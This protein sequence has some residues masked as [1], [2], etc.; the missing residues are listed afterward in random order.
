MRTT[1][2][3]ERPLVVTL[4][5]ILQMFGG[6]VLLLSATV[7]AIGAMVSRSS[8]G[9]PDS[10][11]G[12]ASAIVVGALYLGSG[13]GLWKLRPYGRILQ[14][15]SS[16]LGLLAIPIGTIVSLRILSY[17]YKPAVK[18]LFSGRRST[19]LT[20][21]ELM[22][23]RAIPASSRLTTVIVSIWFA[24]VTVVVLG[25]ATVIVIPGFLRARIAGNEA[26]AIG[27][28]RAIS[29]AERTYATVN[30]GYYATLPCPEHSSPC[31]A[32]DSGTE[33]VAENHFEKDGYRFE[34]QPG[35]AA[36]VTP[37]TASRGNVQTFV[38]VATPTSSATGTRQFCIDQTAGLRYTTDA[39][40]AVTSG[41]CPTDWP[42]VE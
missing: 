27:T 10:P 17:L 33:F 34:Y 39:N 4:L 18:I 21:E 32:T 25:I 15:I 23:I 35:T 2:R 24:V 19:D 14:I 12:W 36:A 16:F 38:V 40:V 6:G 31:L 29:S 11:L 41:R 28:L 1:D 26:S 7:I 22:Q 30:Q 42:S 13:I 20:P 3:L 5:A 9:A 37:A 8:P